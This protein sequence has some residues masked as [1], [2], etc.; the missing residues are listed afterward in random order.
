M[1]LADHRD[2]VTIAQKGLRGSMAKD[3]DAVLGALRVVLQDVEARNETFVKVRVI[4]RWVD[5]LPGGRWRWRN[6]RLMGDLSGEVTR[7]DAV[8]HLR[9][10]LAFLE[11]NRDQIKVLRAWWPFSNLPTRTA[12]PEPVDAEFTDVRDPSPPPRKRGIA[13]VKKKER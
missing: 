1:G 10:T 5:Q 13:L 2:V 3:V 4:N 9:A 11:I 6:L 7:R 12:S 8:G